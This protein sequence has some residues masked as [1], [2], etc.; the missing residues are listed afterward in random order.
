ML[1]L[2]RSH[3]ISSIIGALSVQASLY[4]FNHWC[5]LYA[6]LIVWVQSLVPSL[7]RR[8]CMS[9]IIG[10]LSVQA[11]L[12]QFNHWCTL[13][14]G[15]IVSVQSLVHSLCRPDCIRSIIGAFS[16][17][18]MFRLVVEA[19]TGVQHLHRLH[20]VHGDLSAR[21]LLLSHSLEPRL[22]IADF[23]HAIQ[24]EHEHQCFGD[25]EILYYSNVGKETYKTYWYVCEISSWCLG[26]FKIIASHW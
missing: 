16:V 21:N 26:I 9:S 14:A 5:T 17:Q 4:K 13:Y 3:C 23:G 12:Y 15:L 6:G 2:W 24:L 25:W 7:C 18:E 19:G 20:I 11:S 8:N 1:S 22:K 10:A